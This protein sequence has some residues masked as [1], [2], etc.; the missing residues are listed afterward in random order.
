M[1]TPPTHSASHKL[2]LRGPSRNAWSWAGDA[3][4]VAAVEVMINTP[5]ICE[6]VKKGDVMGSRKR[7]PQAVSAAIRRLIRIGS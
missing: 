1:T 4:R 2:H 7:S 5:H 3:K 6:F